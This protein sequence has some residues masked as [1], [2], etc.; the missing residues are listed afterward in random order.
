MFEGQNYNCC[1]GDQEPDWSLYSHLELDG[2]VEGEGETIG[3]INRDDA[4]FF[5]IYG[6]FIKGGCEA[7][8][9]VVDDYHVAERVAEEH[10]HRAKLPLNIYC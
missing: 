9:D 4:E 1:P 10:A 7:I 6:R 5:T 2:C 3:Q 8:T